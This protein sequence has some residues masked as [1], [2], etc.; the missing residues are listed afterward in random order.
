[1]TAH[2][3]LLYPDAMELSPE[4]RARLSTLADHTEL[5]AG[6]QIAMRD[7]EIRGAGDLLGA[8]QSGHVAALGF[9]LYVE[10]LAE[11]VAELQGQ[12]RLATRPVRVDARVDAYVPA[13]YVAS[14]A[15]KIDI[16]RRLALA[17]SDDELRELHAA[18]EDRYGPVPE[19]VEHLFAIQEAK[20]KL[21]RL[22]ADYLVYRGGRATVG[23]L[24][25]GSAELRALRDVSDTAVYTSAKREV[26]QRAE[27]LKGAISLVDAIVVAR[28]AA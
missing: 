7:L 9:E 27:E 12:R 3:Y 16:H 4:S 13:S 17:E 5:G 11:A 23:P 8:E 28:Q 6:F 2:A 19:P 25:L 15:L 10:M 21:A 22:G 20:L 14:E 1:V 24:V 18:L 26:S